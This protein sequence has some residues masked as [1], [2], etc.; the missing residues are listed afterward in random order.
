MNEL[1]MKDERIRMKE[2]IGINEWRNEL[3]RIEWMNER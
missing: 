1:R 2:Q 3:K